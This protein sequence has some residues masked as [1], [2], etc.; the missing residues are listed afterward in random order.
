M[1]ATRQLARA[2]LGGVALTLLTSPSH[3]D[4]L[5]DLKAQLEALQ[6]RVNTLEQQPVPP[7]FEVPLGARHHARR[8]I[9]NGLR[10]AG[11]GAR[12][13]QPE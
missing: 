8:W 9:A 3:A 11:S 7:A 10:G 6:S 4:Q 12:S 2:L 13:G 1:I 5:A